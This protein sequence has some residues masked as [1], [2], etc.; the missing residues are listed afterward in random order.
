ME[1]EVKEL[2]EENPTDGTA[3]MIKQIMDFI[4]GKTNNSTF[5]AFV[6]NPEGANWFAKNIN[7]KHPE[8][9]KGLNTLWEGVK[10]SFNTEPLVFKDGRK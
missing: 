1:K 8:T 2:F 7:L 5:F 6:V 9:I 4:K 10:K 3:I